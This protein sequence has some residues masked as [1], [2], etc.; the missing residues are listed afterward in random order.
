MPKQPQRH[1]QLTRRA[2]GP[3]GKTEKKQPGGTRLDARRPGRAIEVERSGRV[4]EALRRLAKEKGVKRE[5]KV[6]QQDFDK[7]VEAA[8]KSRISVTVTNISG[9]RRKSLRS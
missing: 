9:T 4:K 3:K 7:A 8:Q 6:P 5:L 1:K 2:A